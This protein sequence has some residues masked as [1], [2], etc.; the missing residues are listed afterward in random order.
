MTPFPANSPTVGKIRVLILT[1][2]MEVGGTQRQIV[3]MAC[4]LDRSHYEVI[5][6]YFC[7]RSFL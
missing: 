5:V 4:A 1:D 7:N 3:N 2:E 6:A